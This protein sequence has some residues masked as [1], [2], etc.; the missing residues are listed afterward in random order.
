M[1]TLAPALAV[2]A[3]AG[4]IDLEQDYQIN[5]DGSGK[6]LVRT[7]FV[8]FRLDVGPD[9]ERSPED[10]LQA[11]VRDEIEKSKGVE[12]WA[13]VA[14]TRR[15]DGKSEFKGTAY[16][17]DLA[18][19]KLHNQGFSGFPGKLALKKT[20]AGGLALEAVPEEEGAAPGPRQL[21]E[22]DVKAKMAEERAQYQQSKAFL[23]GM[24]GELKVRA[25]FALPGAVESTACFKKTG[26]SKAQIGLEGPALMKAFDAL[27]LDDALL[28]K[29]IR[30][31]GDLKGAPPADG[32][33]FEKLFGEKGPPRVTTAAAGAPL[34][35]YAKEAAAA[36]AGQPALL[37]KLGAVPPPP[38]AAQG[39]ALKGVKVM[40]VKWVHATD[41]KRGVRPLNTMEPGLTI[42]ILA[43]LPGAVLSIKE[44]AVTR[45]MSDA[46]EDLL[47]KRDWDRA[48]HFPGLTEDK[49]A[50]SFDVTLKLPGPAAKGI[51]EVS[52]TLT[53]TVGT[54]TRDVDL[55][56]E[57]LTSGA[58]GKEMGA[59]IG[60]VEEP[61]FDKG[62]QT[63]EL[64]L[65][66]AKDTIAGVDF[67][68]AAGG[69]LDVRPSGSMWGGRQTTLTFSLK[70][71]FPAKG[72]VVAKVWQDLQPHQVPFAVKDVD[73]LGRPLK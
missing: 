46:G 47:P 57:A 55:G 71:K 20:A 56:F 50:V 54:T 1:K 63:L 42:A 10:Q 61:A 15:P 60:D 27:M 8:P 66:V 68:D 44:G 33:F 45:A 3:L 26:P 65:A 18:A 4:C 62:T 73:L 48:L 64:K 41:G 49:A 5:P 25:S 23:Q 21:A 59:Q 16:F 36:K 32:A 70:G 53:Y 52:G 11:A 58:K 72:R 24:L 12:A 38:P 40:G 28:E 30:E 7:L 39:G 19:L 51:R 13:D 9:A 6:V 22:A 37:T 34:F 29:Q 67:F 35:D 31:R 69:K 43:E 17:K 14:W 2:L